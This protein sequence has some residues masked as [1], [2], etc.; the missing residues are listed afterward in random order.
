[1]C[2]IFDLTYWRRDQVFVMRSEDSI[3]FLLVSSIDCRRGQEQPIEPNWWRYQVSASHCRSHFDSSWA[4]KGAPNFS[5]GLVQEHLGCCCEDQVPKKQ[6]KQLQI[7]VCIYHFFRYI[8]K[9]II[10]FC[11]ESNLGKFQGTDPR[12]FQK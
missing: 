3:H 9:S 12:L 2:K 6:K 5:R 4:P 8:L 10:H 1:M 11:H 7:Y